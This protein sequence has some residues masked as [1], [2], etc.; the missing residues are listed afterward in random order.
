MEPQGCLDW[1]S[2]LLRLGLATLVLLKSSASFVGKSFLF[3]VIG[4][5]PINLSGIYL[6]Y[7]NTLLENITIH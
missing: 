4:N 5:L 2:I 1:Y 6:I 3:F 7:E